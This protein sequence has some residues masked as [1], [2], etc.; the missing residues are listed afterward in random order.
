MPL[1]WR[2]CL[3]NGLMF[4]A[5]TTAL[6]LAPVT[7]SAT[8]LQ[9]EAVILVVGLIAIVV[10]NSILLR[11]SLAPLDRLVRLMDTVDLQ[12][13]GKRL[14]EAGGGAVGHL[15]QGFNAMLDRLESE[16]GRSNAKALAAQEAERHRIARELHDEI[17]Q[18]LTAVLLGLKGLE[19]GT[20]PK[21]RQALEEVQETARATLD[22]VR[23]VA[24]RLRPGVL[25]DLGLQSALAALATD[26]S[27]H[28]LQVRRV[29]SPGLPELGS[30]RELVIY[31]VAQE[32]LT[33]AAR[34]AQARTVR[35]SLHRQG[36]AVVLSVDDDGNGLRGAEEGTGIRGMRERALL[37]GAELTVGPGETGTSVRLRVPLEAG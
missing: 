15:V 28:G 25:E 24:R 37:I 33:N 27:A 14:S 8:V 23:G 16:R 22:E 32:A 3:I 4:V 35:L 36:A 6:A 29:T 20:P 26:F 17:G 10:L 1:Y 9:S 5:G 13:P 7:V 34:H 12:R 21:L 2:V 19:A 18:G 31:R 11:T 30:E